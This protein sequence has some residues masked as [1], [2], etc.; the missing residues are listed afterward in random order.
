MSD[1][2]QMPRKKGT[3]HWSRV[4]LAVSLALNLAVVGMVAGAVLRH[5]K[6]ERPRR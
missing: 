6:G 5:D 3:F 4:V 2:N 1:L